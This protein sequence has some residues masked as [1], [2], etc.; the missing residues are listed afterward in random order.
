MRFSDSQ[1]GLIV[2]SY[3]PYGTNDPVVAFHT[4]DGGQTWTSEMV[5]VLAGPAYLSQG[6][7]LT[8]ITRVNQVTLLKY[9]E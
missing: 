3:S 4:S 7:Y 8:V 9:E 2:V 1:H 6:G 5:P